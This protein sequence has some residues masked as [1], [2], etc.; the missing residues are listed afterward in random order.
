MNESRHF[1]VRPHRK[2]VE[3]YA[4]WQAWSSLTPESAG[5]VAEGLAGPPSAHKDGDEDTKRFDMLVLRRQL[6]QL[7]GDAIAAERLRE[8]N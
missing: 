7:E 5:D 3:G 6:A 1:R 2:L 4:Q 8:Q